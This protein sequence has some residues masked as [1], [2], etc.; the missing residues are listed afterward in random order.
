MKYLL[1]ELGNKKYLRLGMDELFGT[2]N[3]TEGK[4]LVISRQN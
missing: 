2:C 3:L 1:T 4:K